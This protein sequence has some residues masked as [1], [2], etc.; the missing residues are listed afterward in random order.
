MCESDVLL[1]L[2]VLL[3]GKLVVL[4]LC[5]LQ[6]FS[7]VFAVQFELPKLRTQVSFIEVLVRAAVVVTST[8]T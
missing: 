1:Y 7:L 5:K 6:H 3:A 4:R 2:K 8:C